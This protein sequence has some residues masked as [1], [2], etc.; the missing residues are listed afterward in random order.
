MKPTTA[1]GLFVWKFQLRFLFNW[2]KSKMQFPA[3]ASCTKNATNLLALFDV[4][5][6]ARAS[7]CSPRIELGVFTFSM[8]TP[9]WLPLLLLFNPTFVLIVDEDDEAF[10]ADGI[11]MAVGGGVVLSTMSGPV[12]QSVAPCMR[13][14]LF[15]E[16]KAPPLSV[17]NNIVPWGGLKAFAAALSAAPPPFTARLRW[18]MLFLMAIFWFVNAAIVWP[19]LLLLSRDDELKLLALLCRTTAAACCWWRKLSLYSDRLSI[20]TDVLVSRTGCCCCWFCASL[21]GVV[22]MELVA[23]EVI[24]APRD[25]WCCCWWWC[26]I[27]RLHI[28]VWKKL[29]KLSIVGGWREG[30]TKGMGKAEL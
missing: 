25:D 6:I 30:G 28:C 9:S 27:F 21:F 12:K 4:S 18:F 16:P 20:D 24:S 3:S 14:E 17:L 15:P 19:A 10:D 13:P 1:R 22:E 5:V 11:A 7:H 2:W 26:S 8:P 23:D 29:L